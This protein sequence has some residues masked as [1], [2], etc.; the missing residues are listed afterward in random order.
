MRGNN[1]WIKL[2][3]KLLDN[4]VFESGDSCLVH[5]FLYCLL[6]ANHAEKKV[7]VNGEEITLKPGQFVTGRHIASK[8][9]GFKSKMW[10]RKCDQLRKLEIVTKQV[11]KQCTVITIVNWDK[12]QSQEQ[13]SDQPNDQGMTKLRPSSDQVVTT[14]K[15]DKK[16]KNDKNKVN[17]LVG[18]K[19]SPTHTPDLFDEFVE[20]WNAM[21]DANGLPTIISRSKERLGKFNRLLKDK[22]FADNW[23]EAI[24]LIPN[25]RFLLGDG[26]RGWK[27]DIK[28]FFRRDTVAKIMEG[29][30][31]QHGNEPTKWQR[32][33]RP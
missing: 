4:S 31:G 9:L 14:N 12:Y 13:E 17:T 25:D 33:F 21:A 10:D 8:D 23:R 7:L 30:N 19:P 26:D 27:A 22:F 11:T 18:E 15:N 24:G 5:A 16:V 32:Y 29:S 6:R 3:R 1:G 28:Y 20:V 2:H